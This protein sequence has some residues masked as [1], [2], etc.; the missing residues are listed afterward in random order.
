[1]KYIK[2]SNTINS[3]NVGRPKRFSTEKLKEILDLFFQKNDIILG[4]LTGKRLA[5]FAEKELGYKNI[6]YYHFTRDI[7]IK[8]L[9]DKIN[10]ESTY[11]FN[12]Q[13]RK[14]NLVLLKADVNNFVKTYKNDE[15]KLK[16][17]LTKFQTK[18]ELILFEL[19]KSEAKNE[20]LT[21]ENNKINLVI[22]ELKIEIENFKKMADCPDEIKELR[23]QNRELEMQNKSL[24][25]IVKFQEEMKY[26]GML[27]ERGLINNIDYDN[28]QS[29]LKRNKLIKSEDNINV[30]SIESSYK[31]D[32]TSFKN[33]G[34]STQCNID[35]NLNE[36]EDRRKENLK[37][38]VIKENTLFLEKYLK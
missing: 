31:K 21:I 23:R 36:S 13:S 16:I 20:N 32:Y 5:D 12:Y 4:Q 10:N 6:Y 35:I 26:F 25:K 27:K 30:E 29:L 28:V 19:N 9:I 14:M 3:S 33:N 2:V 34:E 38:D 1:M 11:S 22:K 18:Y 7:E 17:F 24:R 8:V 37:N 15:E